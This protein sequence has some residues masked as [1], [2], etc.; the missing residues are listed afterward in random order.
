MLAQIEPHPMRAY[1][2]AEFEVCDKPDQVFRLKLS[3]VVEYSKTERSE[4]FSLFFY[5]PLDHFMRQGIH[6]L[7]HEELGELEIFLVPTAKNQAGFQ[8]EAAFNH[9]L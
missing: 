8:Y 6:K 4:T 3:E 5:G 2:G 9:L 1:I 7:K